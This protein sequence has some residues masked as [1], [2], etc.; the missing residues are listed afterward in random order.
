RRMAARAGISESVVEDLLLDWLGSLGYEVRHGAEIAPG[1]PS[2]ERDDYREVLLLGRLE[3]S[4][5]RLNPGE[6]EAAIAEAVRQIRKV[7]TPDLV[8]ANR[9]F[10][11][12]LVDGLEVELPAPG[13]GVRGHHLRLLYFDDPAGNDWLA[14]NQ[15]TVQGSQVRRPDVAVF[16]NGL[17]L[18]VVELKDPTDEQAT[19]W[20]A[21]NQLQTYKQDIPAL[22]GPNELLVISD[23]VESRLGS[24]SAPKEWFLPWRTVEG[25]ALAAGTEN[26]LEVLAR[27]VF[28][29]ERFLD[30]VRHFVAFEDD[31]VQ[32]RKVIAGYHQFHAVRKAVD[33]TILASSEEGD[34]RAGVVWHTQG[35]GKSLTMAFFAGKLILHPA[36]ANPTIFVLTDRNDLD[37]QL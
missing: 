12:M 31:G 35:S 29:H 5:R 14:V 2:A 37:D 23:G 24:L 11:R 33:R 1:E 8:A 4:L 20:K 26:T 36:M 28:E 9:R 18:A 25:D 21:Y 27:G 19:V 3:G 6:P 32:V 7:D 10:H 16:V 13:G 22:F 15:F 30:L 34:R 17:P